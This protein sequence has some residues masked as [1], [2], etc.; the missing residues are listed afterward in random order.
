VA[1]SNLAT[2][3]LFA[4]VAIPVVGAA[5]WFGGGTLAM[6]IALASALAAWEFCRLATAAGYA[7]FTG[8]TTSLAGLTPLALH[9]YL[10]GSFA[11]PVLSLGAMIVLFFM[12]ASLFRRA[13]GRRPLGAAAVSVFAI[14]YTGGLLSFAYA[15]RYHDYA[16][17]A[18]AG[19]ALLFYPLV[20]AWATD[21]AAYFAGRAFGKRKLMPSVSPA[22]TVAGA[23]AG[24][25]A[26][27]LV[28]W[29]YMQWVLV[30]NASLAMIPWVALAAGAAL[31]VAAQTG[32]LAESLLKR[33]AGVKDSSRI[34]PG[35]G[36]VLDRLDSLIFVIPAAYFLFT[37]PHVLL[38]VVR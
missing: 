7:P 20:I 23:V 16:I 29:G 12:A 37:F 19:T 22:K 14:L 33:E 25:T 11:P 9:G 2:R 15:L 31:S 17:G 30:P 27:M 38:P 5:V 8:V 18:R 26:A 6:L 21:I 34:I 28:S 4:V 35:H 3:V 1:L 13:P 36:G 32:D 24:M 10:T